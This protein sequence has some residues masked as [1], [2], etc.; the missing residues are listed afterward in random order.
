MRQST[1]GALF[2]ALA[3]WSVAGTLRAQPLDGPPPELTVRVYRVSDLVLSAPPHAYDGI[4]LPGKA[5]AETGM[6]GMSGGFGGG[7]GGFGGGGMGGGGGG[8]GG[9]GVGGAGETAA[10]GGGLLNV[11][12]PILA[13]FGDM[14]GAGGGGMMGAMMGSGM[15]GAGSA[16][17]TSTRFGVEDLMSAIR[18]NIAP[19]SWQMVGGLGSIVPLGGMLIVRQTEAVHL[20]IEELLNAL[21]E[22]GGAARTVTVQAEW[23]LLDDGD[24]ERLLVPGKAGR[25]IDPAALRELPA[26]QRPYRGEVTCFDGQTVHLVSGR[27]RTVVQS[28]VPV[29][30]G[31]EV[32]YQPVLASISAGAL[33]QLTPSLAANKESAVVDFDSRVTH[34]DEPA[35]P[36]EFPRAFSLDRSNVVV[37]QFGS[38]L[39]VP[40]GRPVVAGGLTLGPAG[41]GNSAAGHATN[42]VEAGGIGEGGLSGGAG[43]RPAGDPARAGQQ[44]YLILTITAAAPPAGLQT[45]VE[46]AGGGVGG[47]GSDRH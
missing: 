37:H 13:Q 15:G 24:L 34:W 9:G 42:N 14:Q 40:L 35:A 16:G 11:D 26:A 27:L 38:T 1:Y 36:L 18:S 12:D 19:E 4:H 5:S 32:G 33:L 8:F 29:V 43:G 30:G 44:L 20:Q 22:E 39:Q 6:G 25:Q 41:D 2:A 10:G 31:Q 45:G 21:R 23:L 46:D 28:A 47:A 7:G 3:V 17:S